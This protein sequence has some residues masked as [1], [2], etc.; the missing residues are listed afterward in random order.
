LRLRI[1][2]QTHGAYPKFR[3]DRCDQRAEVFDL[4]GFRWNRCA[5]PAVD[6]NQQRPDALGEHCHL[7]LLQHHRHHPGVVNRLQ[8]E[9]AI[10]G[11]ANR[12]GDE[13]VG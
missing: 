12:P 6:L 5:E 9:G 13:S 11:L 1:P 3:V 2:T 10:S 4:G 8:V 7:L